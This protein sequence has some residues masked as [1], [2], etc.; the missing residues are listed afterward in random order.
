MI[1][2]LKANYIFLDYIKRYMPWHVFI[3]APKFPEYLLYNPD[4]NYGNSKQI[5]LIYNSKGKIYKFKGENES[6]VDIS[7]EFSYNEITKIGKV[8][9]N[10]DSISE[11]TITEWLDNDEVNIEIKYEAD[12]DLNCNARCKLDSGNNYNIEI[13]INGKTLTGDYIAGSDVIPQI[14]YDLVDELTLI[15]SNG[16]IAALNDEHMTTAMAVE[17]WKNAAFI[18]EIDNGLSIANTIVCAIIDILAGGNI[19]LSLALEILC[20]L[21]IHT[22]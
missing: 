13:D 9:I 22:I 19:M 5:E 18:G 12:N 20:M 8:E 2:T 16:K 7:V 14:A 21:I 17:L 3:G 6:G 4:T 15:K 10:K 1:K 11:L